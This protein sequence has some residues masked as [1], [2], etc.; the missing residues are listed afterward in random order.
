MGKILFSLKK[1][2]LKESVLSIGKMSRKMWRDAKNYHYRN[3]G[4][5]KV[6]ITAQSP[7]RAITLICF[8]QNP[9]LAGI[10]LI[11]PLIDVAA[12]VFTPAVYIQCRQIVADS[13]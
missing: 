11:I 5:C 1:S 3:G 7:P 12:G 4:D 8:F 13:C 10:A 2:D 9:F 6:Y